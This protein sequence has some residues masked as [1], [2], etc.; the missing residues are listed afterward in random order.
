MAELLDKRIL[1]LKYKL[2]ELRRTYAHQPKPLDVD[3][4]IQIIEE[5]L[6]Q[7]GGFGRDGSEYH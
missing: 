5:Q 3:L 2:E 4:E 6:K 1:R 7:L